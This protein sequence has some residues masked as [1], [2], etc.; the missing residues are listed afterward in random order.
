MSMHI[1]DTGELADNAPRPVDARSV[2]NGTFE[3]LQEGQGAVSRSRRATR[4]TSATQAGR[5]SHARPREEV[6][7]QLTVDKKTLALIV[8]GALVVIAVIVF[9]F[10][11]ALSGTVPGTKSAPQTEAASVDVGQSITS[12]GATYE[13]VESDGKYQ[14][15]QMHEADGGQRVVLADIE[16]TPAGLVLHEGTLLVPQNHEDGTWDVMAY[17]IGWGSG[18]IM[19]QDGN[20]YGGSGTVSNPELNDHVLVLA[21]DGKRVEIPLV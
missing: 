20:A 18:Q 5:S 13:L 12:Y 21:V 1:E 10:I 6:Q 17:T 16:G 3:H 19:D 9:F 2:E 11:R 7:E 8:G 15:V 14:L 4:G